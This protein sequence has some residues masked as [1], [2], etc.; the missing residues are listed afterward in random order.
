M[1]RLVVQFPGE[2]KVKIDGVIRGETNSVIRLD[3]GDHIV[4]LGGESTEPER[5]A[6]AVPADADPEEIVRIGFGP[7]QQPINRF[8]AVYC[9]YNGFLL[10]Q[11]LSLSFARYGRNQYFVRRARMVEFLQEVGVDA[12]LPDEPLDLGGDSHAQLL[13][14]VLP[15]IAERSHDLMEFTLV[16]ALLTHYGMLAEHDPDTAKECLAEVER[17]RHKHDLPAVAAERFIL[18]A[19][20]NVD[21]VLSPSLAYLGQAIDKLDVE[22]DTA[23]V[24]MPFKEPYAGYFAR[25]YRPSLEEAGYRAFR[26]WGG[27]SNEDYCDLLL[28]LIGKVGLVWADVSELNYNVLYEI[29]AAHALG[30]LSMLVVR[31]DDAALIP[32]NIGHDAVIRYSVAD[33]DWPDGTVRLMAAL[34]ASLKV[35]VERGERLRVGP[36]GVKGA[37]EWVGTRLKGLLVAPEARE[38]ARAGREK[39]GA[40]DFAGAERCFDEAIRLGLNDALTMLGRGATHMAVGRYADAEAD[41]TKVLEAERH[42][43]DEREQQMSAAYLRGMAREQ[44]E[45]YFG[46]RDDYGTAIDL[47]YPDVEVH[48]RRAFVS[49]KLDDLEAARRDVE[50]AAVLAPDDAATHALRGDLLAAEQRYDDAVA[51]Y[52]QALGS[53]PNADFA[54]ARALVLLLAGHGGEAVDAYHTAAELADDDAIDYALQDLQ[55]KA[56]AKPGMEECRKVLT[57]ARHK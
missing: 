28:K 54:L 26:A 7:A 10:G 22:E 50:R 17:I 47:G 43:P 20:S 13:M 34:I 1:A 33:N 44:Q 53:E 37:L 24:I 55:K 8:S 42:A 12:A 49:L 21:A 52:D 18:K 19:D 30:K 14:S 56:T 38:A 35:A 36:E 39:H 27:L 25:F 32:A 40:G 15:K 6:F 48:R 51:E 45:N 46:A 3:P 29:G 11:F 4:E 16:G 23:F 57:D 5:H 9:R 41:F 2:A 31:E